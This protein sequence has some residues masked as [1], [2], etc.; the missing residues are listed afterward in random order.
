MRFGFVVH[1]LNPVQRGLVAVRTLS[2]AAIAGNGG[3]GGRVA[4]FHAVRSACGAETAGCVR[5]VPMLPEA[6][7]REQQEAVERVAVAVRALAEFDRA[8]VVGLGSLCAVVGLRGEEVARRSPVPVTTGSSFTAFAAVRTLERTAAALGERLHGSTVAVAGHPGAL[9]EGIGR[10]LAARG[11]D[12]VPIDGPRRGTIPAP[13][14]AEA[15]RRA[16]FVVGASSTGDAI[17]PAWL[18]PG[19][20][21]VDVAEPRDLRGRTPAEVLV[22]DGE[23]VTAPPDAFAGGPFTRLYSFVVG[24]RGGTVYACFAEPVV[25]ALEREATPYSLGRTIDV[26]RSERIGRLA[27]RHGFVVD[28]LLRHG[29]RVAQASIDRVAARRRSATL[30]EGSP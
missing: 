10:L 23:N 12:V 6:M 14:P 22:V 1:P 3:A 28:R 2:P 27:E 25:L 8:D 19:S 7:L 11:A 13:D 26:E 15:V 21:V 9:A 29:R 17:D 20:V 18:V 5:A 4:T 24:H 16:D 30:R